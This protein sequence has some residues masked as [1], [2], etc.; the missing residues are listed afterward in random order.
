MP[1]FPVDG[2]KYR[3]GMFVLLAGCRSSVAERLGIKQAILDSI[4]GGDQ[5]FLILYCFFKA[6]ERERMHLMTLS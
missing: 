4:P 1:D 6:Y 5:I 2:H 3:I